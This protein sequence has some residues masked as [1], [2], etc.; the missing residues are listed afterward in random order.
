MPE[1][2]AIFLTAAD[3]AAE[4][5]WEAEAARYDSARVEAI[6]SI[7]RQS[8]TTRPRN[9]GNTVR[10][11]QVSS[12][13]ARRFLCYRHSRCRDR[14]SYDVIDSEVFSVA[15]PCEFANKRM[16]IINI[17]FGNATAIMS[18]S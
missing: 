3:S 8:T 13:N 11:L 4:P 15:S 5:A 1:Y 18:P 2:F 10:T 7:P 6:C 12:E 16:L 14:A 9:Q 17:H